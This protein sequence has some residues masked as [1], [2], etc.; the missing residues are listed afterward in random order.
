VPT[1]TH[2]W[3][4]IIKCL[5]HLEW[6]LEVWQG[7]VANLSSDIYWRRIS[8]HRRVPRDPWE[9]LHWVCTEEDNEAI[10]INGRLPEQTRSPED[11]R[12]KT[13]TWLTFK[14]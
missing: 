9:Q 5:N 7:R 8:K 3:Q 11:R 4:W 13:G 10:L 2:F 1:R 14:G 12:P 6:T